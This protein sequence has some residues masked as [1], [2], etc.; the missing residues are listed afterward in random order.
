MNQSVSIWRETMWRY[1]S[2]LVLFPVTKQNFG[3]IFVFYARSTNCH[4]AYIYIK[5]E[6]T[7]RQSLDQH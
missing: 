1:K 4:Y 3:L 5:Q 7:R 6:A 2:P